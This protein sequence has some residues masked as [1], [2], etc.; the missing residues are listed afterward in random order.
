MPRPNFT[1]SGDRQRLFEAILETFLQNTDR[2]T[3]ISPNGVLA[4][5]LRGSA[6]LAQRAIKDISISYV[7]NNIN[8]ASG[9]QLDTLAGEM[10]YPPRLPATSSTSYLRLVGMPGTIYNVDEVSY[11]SASG[12]EFRQEVDSFTIPNEG[13]GY[14]SI[15]SVNTGSITNVAPFSISVRNAPAG[16]LRS[17]NEFSSSRGR[18]LETDEAYKERIKSIFNT[19]A[20]ATIPRIQQILQAFDPEILRIVRLGT[21]TLGDIRIGIVTV[22]G[23]TY[24]AVELLDLE[25]E[26]APYMALSDTNA[27]GTA[28]NG[29]RFQNIEYRPIDFSIRI[30]KDPNV[31][32]IDIYQDLS[33]RF[34]RHINYV[35]WQFGIS[36]VDRD[37][38]VNETIRANGVRY[39][40]SLE[41]TPMQDILIS[42]DRLPRIRRIELFDLEGQR[43][44]NTSASSIETSTFQNYFFPNSPDPTVAQLVT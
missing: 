29:I 10:G 18:D 9:S 38:L 15:R 22:N 4:G 14:I 32:V 42:P 16:H 43:I 34:N 39:V 37:F 28:L 6:R 21:S 36:R 44:L 1:E 20:F 26:A 25:R 30:Q 41:F 12:I 24:N 13:Y 3:K 40:E 7:D 35:T 19:L 8:S 17:F 27:N 33:I 11:I 31:D 5:I 2:V 23:K